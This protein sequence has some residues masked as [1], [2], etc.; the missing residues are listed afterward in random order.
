MLVLLRFFSV[1]VGLGDKVN[2]LLYFFVG[3]IEEDILVR[4]KCRMGDLFVFV[5]LG[6]QVGFNSFTGIGTGDLLGFI[7]G[8]DING[9]ELV[10]KLNGISVIFFFN[11]F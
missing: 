2:M 8:I 6:F 10:L 9:E 3:Y 4:I 11:D 7:K 5:Y 1:V